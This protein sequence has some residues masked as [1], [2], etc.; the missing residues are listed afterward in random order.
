MDTIFDFDSTHLT[1]EYFNGSPIYTFDNFYKDPTAVI[2]FID[3]HEPILWK[4]WETQTYNGIFFKDL[5]HNIVDDRF[6]I[7]TDFLS[8]VCN[9]RVGEPTKIVTNKITFKHF[10]FNDYFNNYWG[11]HRDMGYNGIIYLNKQETFTNLYTC[12]EED[13]WQVPEHAAPWRSKSKYKVE[14]QLTGKF[15]RLILFDG[16]KF[17]HGMSIDNDEFFRDNY[18]FNQVVFF[19]P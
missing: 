14:K 7:V 15:N 16:A 6:G 19:R 4:N 10:E 3:S 9:Q 17:L 13:E 2:D 1:I 8:G 12:V 5:R 18:R 11:P